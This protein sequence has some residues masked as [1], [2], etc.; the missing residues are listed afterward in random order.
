MIHWIPYA[1]LRIVLFF[2]MGI[3]LAIAF[4]EALDSQWA[5]AIFF[6][7][8]LSYGII[9]LLGF[10]SGYLTGKTKF[11]AGLTG[12]L[13]IF[14]AGYL[15]VLLKTESGKPDHFIH[16][17]TPI[18]FSKVLVKGVPEEKASSWK[19]ETEV[20][21]VKTAHGWRSCAGK[22]LLYVSKQGLPKPFEYGDVILIKG[23]PQLI[24]DPSNPEEFDYKRFMAFKNIY[25]QQFV[26]YKD[27]RQIGFSPP[28]QTMRL[29]FKARRWADETLKKN[30]S[31]EREQALASALVLG[32]TDGLDNE[33]LSAYKATGT[34]HVLAVSGLHVAIL[35]GLVIFLL[36]PVNKLKFGPWIIALISIFILWM[37]AFVTGLSPSVLRAVT[38]FSFMAL[39][40][41][42]GRHTNIY[43][44][45]AASAFCILLYDPFLLMS[46]GFQ[47]SY[48]AV[49]GIVYLQPALYNLW[50]PNNR[51]MDEIWKVSCVSVAAQLATLALGLYY[52]HQ[53]P[54]YFLISNLFV[55]P[56]SFVVLMLGILILVVDFIQ[57]LALMLGLLMEWTIKAIN[58]IV[59]GIEKF[60]FAMVENV[61]ITAFQCW[62]L[63]SIIV[64][65]IM[66]MERRKIKALYAMSMLM[67]V[68]SLTQWYHFE[69]NIDVHKLMVYNVRGHSAI[70]MID[71]GR[72][73]FMADSLLENDAGKVSFHITPNRVKSGVKNIFLPGD[74]FQRRF[75]GCAV[76][77][78]KGK[79]VLLIKNMAYSFPSGISVD[80]VIVSNDA[81]KDLAVLTSQ[82]Q[83][84]YLVLDSS[85]SNYNATRL[86]SQAAS[87]LTKVYSV[88][89]QGAFE[90]NI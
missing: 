81:V 12:L 64:A 75:P 26:K 88:L 48:L 32:V 28:S 3:S 55:I 25:H 9:I 73:Y 42:M 77:V 68:F 45:L 59:F 82:I 44:T 33:L 4:P 65:I 66:L 74:A 80:V 71:Q 5:T 76:M 72:A 47:L 79:S 61:Y 57:P 53:F 8:L 38:M 6:G 35:Y 34:M 56:G 37:Y 69:K 89:H 43:N 58:F 85:N 18:E 36:R 83:M 23:S 29:A 67:V 10:R 62:L 49:L 84:K 2:M 86:L 14:L 20:Q 11:L 78:W 19:I 13:A 16:V 50:E 52:F 51:L 40:K 41:P 70:D 90:L 27:I 60:P 1:F 24:A 87:G 31:G 39:A 7:I 15:N 17:E 46:V 63:I 22:L 30:I 21:A 54:N